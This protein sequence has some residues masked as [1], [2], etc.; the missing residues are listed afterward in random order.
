MT[1]QSTLALVKQGDVQAINSVINYLLKKKKIKAGASLKDNCLFLVLESD[2]PLEKDITIHLVR[3]MLYKLAI[4]NIKEAKIES[5]L[6]NSSKASWVGTIDLKSVAKSSA[7]ENSQKSAIVP[8]TPQPSNPLPTQLST[9]PEN[10]N[11]N[12][13]ENQETTPA[14]TPEKFAWSPWFPYPSSWLR[15]LDLIIWFAIIVRITSY[16]ATLVGVGMAVIS[17]N[18]MMLFHAF[19]LS[20]VTSVIIF[21]YI[22][23]ILFGRKADGSHQFS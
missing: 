13:S 20:L 5:R 8:P 3:E 1:Q 9:S 16:W 7:K 11:N 21:A 12:K 23:H 4:A 22:N 15:T 17:D 2:I 14:T 19:G 18:P 10:Q 6:E